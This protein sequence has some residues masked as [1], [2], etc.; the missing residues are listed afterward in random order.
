MV[1]K[2]KRQR[3]EAPGWVWMTFGLG[4]GLVVAL[5][6]Y[7]NGRQ[8][9]QAPLPQAAMPAHQQS[10]ETVEPPKTE[11]PPAAA[12]NKAEPEED[13]DRFDF[14]DLLPRFEV[15]VPEVETPSPRRASAAAIEDPGTYVLQ[16]GSFGNADDAERQRA[17]L[18]LLGLESRVQRVSIDDRTFHRVRIGPIE[19]LDELNAVRARLREADVDFLVM[20][21]SD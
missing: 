14:Y 21:M 7:L 11:D 12:D 8:A 20:R 9:A 13:T 5:G 15:I 18:A 6:V 1:R 16:A 4:I 2:R 3:D 19:K 17:N 10:L